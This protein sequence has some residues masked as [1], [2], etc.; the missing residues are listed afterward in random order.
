M[1]Y[2]KNKVSHYSITLKKYDTEMKDNEI[3]IIS[4][5]NVE[6]FVSRR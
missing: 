3:K 1:C 4:T 6:I 2:C 5:D